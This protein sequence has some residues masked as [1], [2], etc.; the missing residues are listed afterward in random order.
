MKE[1]TKMKVSESIVIRDG[2]IY[3]LWLQYHSVMAVTVNSCGALFNTKMHQKRIAHCDKVAIHAHNT[4]QKQ[5]TVNNIPWEKWTVVR[6]GS[7]THMDV[8]RKRN[9][10][11]VL[12]KVE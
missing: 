6:M 9:Q 5:L 11:Y 8:Q 12:E 10:W 3:E 7:P 4:I 1:A 2:R